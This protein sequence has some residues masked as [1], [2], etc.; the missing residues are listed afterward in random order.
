MG[1]FGNSIEKLAKQ[2]DANP[3][4]SGDANLTVDGWNL[5]P[6]GMYETL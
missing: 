6:P 1:L 3:A 4:W 2:E 5:A